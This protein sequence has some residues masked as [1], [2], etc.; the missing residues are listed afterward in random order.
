MVNAAVSPMQDAVESVL[1]LADWDKFKRPE[2]NRLND[3]V[4]PTEFASAEAFL[5]DENGDVANNDMSRN[6]N[7]F[8]PEDCSPEGI[9][10]EGWFKASACK[11]KADSKTIELF[12][13]RRIPLQRLRGK[14]QIRSP[15]ACEFLQATVDEKTGEA[16]GY[17]DI[18]HWAGSKWCQPSE[19][20]KQRLGHLN[21][22]F[23]HQASSAGQDAFFDDGSDVVSSRVQLLSGIWIKR[24]I[25]WGVEIKS[26]NGFSMF[27]S[28]DAH[29]CYR[30]FKDRERFGSRRAAL[31]HWVGEHLR[32]NRDTGEKDILVKQ[33]IRGRIPFVWHGMQCEIVVAPIEVRMHERKYA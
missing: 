8:R 10:K 15:F 32:M 2:K 22:A 28:S 27:L 21:R 16:N 24:D 6:E 5:F 20:R 30:A 23:A 26:P 19:L 12:S 1:L 17:R 31:A 4:W 13:V 29:G 14:C 18:L 7:Y 33:H 3:K 11:Y 9:G 25:T